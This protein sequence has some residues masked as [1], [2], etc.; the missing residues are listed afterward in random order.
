MLTWE[1]EEGKKVFLAGISDDAPDFFLFE[2]E[3][4]RIRDGRK[5]VK[6]NMTLIRLLSLLIYSRAHDKLNSI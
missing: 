6:L 1:S 2:I 3:K 5:V 4:K